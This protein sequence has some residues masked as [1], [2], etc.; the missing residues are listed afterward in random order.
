MSKV[1]TFGEIMMRLNPPG[2][3][4][5]LQTNTFEATYAGGEANV[6]VSLAN[7][8]ND[9]AFPPLRLLT[10]MNLTGTPFL[11]EQTGSTLPESHPPW[12]GNCPKSAWMPARPPKQRESPSAAI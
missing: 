4:R 12:A 9:A 5:F 11:T 6:A 7:Y 2:Y 8:G 10:G 1:I 3:Q